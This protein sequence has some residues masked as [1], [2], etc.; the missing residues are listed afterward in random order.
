VL[1]EKNWSSITYETVK[2]KT[3]ELAKSRNV[4][5]HYFVHRNGFSL[6]TRTLLSQEFPAGFEE[7]LIVFQ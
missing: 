7:K 3:R 5:Q 6:H 2:Y 1:E 4:T